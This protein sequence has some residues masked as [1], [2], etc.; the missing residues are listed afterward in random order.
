[1]RREK[2]QSVEYADQAG[3]TIVALRDERAVAVLPLVR[4]LFAPNTAD[5]CCFVP[6]PWLWNVFVLP[7]RHRGSRRI[8]KREASV[9]RMVGGK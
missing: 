6:P 1:M 7:R 5:A 3:N 4:H 8:S 9:C 2:E